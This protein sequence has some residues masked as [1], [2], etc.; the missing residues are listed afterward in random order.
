MARGECTASSARPPWPR[1]ADVR[2][3]RQTED[4]QGAGW[5]EGDETV[6]HQSGR[7]IVDILTRNPK[8]DPSKYTGA[9]TLSRPALQRR[10]TL[11]PA[12]E[13]DLAHMRRVAAYCKRHLAREWSARAQA[14]GQGSLTP[15]ADA[16][17]SR[18]SRTRRARPSCARRRASRASPT[19][20]T[21]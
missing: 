10:L 17:R 16:Q 3:R 13:E 4:S 11:W 19:G 18:S 8:K 7:K 1:H 20:A 5:G 21:T 2:A 12:V 9:C 6:G 15:T 14:R